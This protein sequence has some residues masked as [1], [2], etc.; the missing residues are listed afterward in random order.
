MTESDLKAMV[1]MFEAY[2]L[3]RTHGYSLGPMTAGIAAFARH[4]KA[5]PVEC[6]RPYKR[7]YEG[8]WDDC[9]ACSRCLLN[10]S[11]RRIADERD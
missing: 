9:R 5:H 4:I 6:E 2:E 10:Q 11:A 7:V 8:G 1:E 3:L